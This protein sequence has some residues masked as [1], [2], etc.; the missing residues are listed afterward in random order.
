MEDW[1]FTRF[2][3]TIGSALANPEPELDLQGVHFIDPYVIAGL[4]MTELLREQSFQLLNLDPRVASYLKR[5]NFPYRGNRALTFP[6]DEE[7]SPILLELFRIMGREDGDT[8]AGHVLHT[9]QQR[10]GYTARLAHTVFDAL[11]EAFQNSLE[12]GCWPPLV[13]M[14]V[15]K[16]HDREQQRLVLSVI[17]GGIGIQQSL[18]RNPRFAYL[19]DDRHALALALEKGISGVAT[20]DTRGQGL[21]HLQQICQRYGGRLTLRSGTAQIFIGPE[22]KVLWF[23]SPPIPGTQLRLELFHLQ[24]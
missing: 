23:G 3:E 14:Q 21:W 20:D 16:R 13:I 1:S 11:S 2:N 17:D 10:L 5:M 4:A 22:K 8:V 9:V 12:H 24:R 6:H 15:F 19:K 18:R 7:D